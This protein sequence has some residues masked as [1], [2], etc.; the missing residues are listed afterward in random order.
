MIPAYDRGRDE[1]CVEGRALVDGPIL[2]TA[3][4]EGHA[5]C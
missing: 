5:G 1:C 4:F 3:C 2:R